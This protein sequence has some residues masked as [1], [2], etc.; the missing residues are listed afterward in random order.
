MVA[1]GPLLYGKFDNG[2]WMYNGS[3]WTQ[4]TANNP[5]AMAASGF[6]LYGDFGPTGIWMYSGTTWSQITP[7]DPTVMFV[8]Y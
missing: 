1:A 2:I 5:E 6:L 3:T 4:V 8:P 7:N